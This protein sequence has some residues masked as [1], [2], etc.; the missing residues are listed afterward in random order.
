MGHIKSC[1]NGLYVY[2]CSSLISISDI[3]KWKPICLLTFKGIF[4]GCSSLI[5]LP[6]IS[7]WAIIISTNI[8]NL[9]EDKLES[10]RKTEI[11]NLMNTFLKE[12][13]SLLSSSSSANLE[14]DLNN[15]KSDNL[16][17]LTNSINSYLFSL[18]NSNL[19]EKKLF[20]RRKQLQ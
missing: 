12:N 11:E 20:Q 15:I 5:S 6:D 9:K 16:I 18:N 3:S 17:N 8:T 4:K 10:I 1:T 13:N 14:N 2:N 7:N 19:S